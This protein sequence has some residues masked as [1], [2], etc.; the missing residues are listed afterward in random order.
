[1]VGGAGGGGGGG[2][3]GRGGSQRHAEHSGM[4]ASARR[5]VGVMVGGGEA[6]VI[7]LNIT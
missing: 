4:C 7:F 6:H 3:G 1:M 2:A 5:K